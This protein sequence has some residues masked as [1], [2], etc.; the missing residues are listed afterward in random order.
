MAHPGGNTTGVSILGTELDGKRQEILIE[1]VPRLRAMAAL[2]DTNTTSVAK[3]QALQEA[4]TARSITLSIHQ[5]T[6]GEE[7]AAAISMA[8]G[9][10]ATALNV[11]SSPMLWANRHLIMDS[12]AALRLPTIYEW[13]EMAEEGGFIAYGPRLVDVYRDLQARQLAQLFRGVKPADIPVEQ[14]TKFE[15]VFNLKTAAVPTPTSPMG[16]R[17]PRAAATSCWRRS[18]TGTKPSSATTPTDRCSSSSRTAIV[19]R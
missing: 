17:S 2:A 9:S 6:K 19:T 8:K 4:V 7:I 18:A 10:G 13:P 3:L 16:L 12:V 11:L 15:L 14:P 1:A 5:I